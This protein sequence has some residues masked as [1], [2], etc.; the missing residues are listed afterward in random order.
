MLKR[1]LALAAFLFMCALPAFT[2]SAA[3]AVT[4]PAETI[5]MLQKAIDTNDIALAE[6]YLDIDAVLAKGVENIAVDETLLRESNHPAINMAL[7]LG[8]HAGSE[9]LRTLLAAEAR[10]YLRHGVVSGAFAGNPKAD[11]PPYKG[12]FPKA[13]RGGDKDKRSF[14][15][16]TVTKT[17]GDTAYLKA[18][19]IQ[20]RKNKTLPL[21]LVA[22]KQDGVWRIVEVANAAELVGGGKRDK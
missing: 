22:R 4:G 18:S 8:P 14:G 21:E 5:A 11:A 9:I 13:F 17:T 19:I 7:A 12:I 10:E 15:K 6:K 20:G 2:A 3:P 16:T 1:I